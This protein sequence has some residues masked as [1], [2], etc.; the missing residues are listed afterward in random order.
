PRLPGRGLTEHVLRTAQPLLANPETMNRLLAAGEVE[1]VGAPSLDWLGVPLMRSERAFGVLAVQSYREDVRFGEQHRD[2]LTF[3]SSQVAAAI[4]RRRAADALRE[5]ESRFRTLAETAPCAITIEQAGEGRYA[6]PA[7]AALTGSSARELLGMSLTELVHPD[8][9]DVALEMAS[10]P[11]SCSGEPIRR[12]LRIVGKDGQ[13]R[14][15][16]FSVSTIEHGGKGA[17]LVTAFDV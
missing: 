8:Q 16:D 7:A 13:E 12:E 4:D 3:V 15:L 14:W 1:L 6:N 5:S 11:A 9:Q 17:A 10:A 2:V